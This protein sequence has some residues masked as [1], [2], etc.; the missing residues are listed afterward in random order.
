VP[1]QKPFVKPGYVR[2]LLRTL[3]DMDI[4]DEKE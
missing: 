4:V 2:L 3:E 1:V